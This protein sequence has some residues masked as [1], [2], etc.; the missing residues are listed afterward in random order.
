MVENFAKAK[1][2]FKITLYQIFA[3]AKI[4]SLKQAHSH[5]S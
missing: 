3:Q 2:T 1:T 4:F 5:S